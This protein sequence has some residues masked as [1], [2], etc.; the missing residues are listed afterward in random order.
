VRYT[1]ELFT[2]ARHGFAVPDHS[3]Y[4]E[5]AAERHWDRVLELFDAELGG[6]RST[7]PA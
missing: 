1:L 7:S 6:D 2:G 4:D 5:R 3:V